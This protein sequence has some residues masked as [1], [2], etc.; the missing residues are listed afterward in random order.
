MV[1]AFVQFVLLLL[2]SVASAQIS[3]WQW[4]KQGGSTSLDAMGNLCTDANGDVYVIGSFGFSNPA[5]S[6]I[7]FDNDTVFNDGVNQIFLVK[8]SGNG[9]ILWAKSIGGY[10]PNNGVSSMYERGGQVF[11][12]AS[13]NSILITGNFSGGYN[14][15]ATTLFGIDDLFLAKLDLNGNFIWAKGITVPAIAI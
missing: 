11:Y 12:D 1:K 13:T 9:A 6:Y 3:T 7:I 15:G 4:A 14:F 5:T 8:Y 10:N 2:C